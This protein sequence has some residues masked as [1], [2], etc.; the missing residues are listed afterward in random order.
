ME[1]AEGFT[2]AT[3]VERGEYAYVHNDQLDKIDPTG[4]DGTWRRPL[5]AGRSAI[6]HLAET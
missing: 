6:F 1:P 5:G 4:L 3:I 2:H